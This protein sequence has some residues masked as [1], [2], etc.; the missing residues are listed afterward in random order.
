MTKE[1]EYKGNGNLAI[2]TYFY[3]KS[4]LNMVND[5]K[6]IFA[7]LFTAYFT[8]KFSNPYIIFALFI[9]GLPILFAMGYVNTHY[10][11][12]V[13]EWLTIKYGSH[14]SIKQYELM[15]KQTKLLQKLLKKLK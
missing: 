1:D 14:Y 12:R 3:I 13:V 11:S 4:G 15:E 9:I 6:Y 5:F 2:R 10:I 8:F 7:G